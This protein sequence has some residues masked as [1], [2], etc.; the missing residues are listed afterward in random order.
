MRRSF[1]DK[2]WRRARWLLKILAGGFD[3]DPTLTALIGS[4]ACNRGMALSSVQNRL[5]NDLGAEAGNQYLVVVQYGVDSSTVVFWKQGIDSER[6]RLRSSKYMN[7][8]IDQD[9]R[10]IK[11]R[12][13]PMLGFENF[14]SAVTTISES[15]PRQRQRCARTLDALLA[16]LI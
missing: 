14:S 6:T 5:P 11:S 12:T 9:H 2:K 10:G 13:G 8:L 7:N 1:T 16:V 4:A 3:P 15:P